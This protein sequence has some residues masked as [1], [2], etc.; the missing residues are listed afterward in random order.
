MKLGFDGAKSKVPILAMAVARTPQIAARG[1]A[2]IGL[3][4]PDD[5]ELLRKIRGLKR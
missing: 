1:S 5:Q 3:V 2:E 4:C